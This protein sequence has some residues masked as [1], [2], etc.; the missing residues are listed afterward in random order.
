M[1]ILIISPHTD[2]AELGCGGGIIKFIEKGHELLWIALSTAEESLPKGFPKDSLKREFLV[3]MEKLGLDNKSYKIFNFRVRS[4]HEHRQEILEEFMNIRRSFNPELV[5]GPSL[6]DFHQDHQLVANE[7]TR[8]FKTTASIIC[9]ELPWNH[10]TFNTQLF[11]KLNEDQLH[12]K[13]EILK[14]YQSQLTNGKLYFSDEFI[15][16]L[17]ATRGVQCN[18]RYAEAFEVVRWMI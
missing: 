8:A 12:K 15:I 6:N 4:L 11:I 16:G 2:D 18:S 9:Y 13:C 14:S 7:M 3:V 10:I 5:I 1:K 17:A